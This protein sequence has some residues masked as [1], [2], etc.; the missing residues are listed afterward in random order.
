[1]VTRCVVVG[2]LNFDI[3]LQTERLPRRHEK[4]RASGVLLSAGGAAANT[5]YWLAMDGL[6]VTMVGAVGDDHFGSEC[7]KSLLRVGVDISSVDVVAEVR[8]G[9]ATVWTTPR[10]KRMITVPGPAIDDALERFDSSFLR[11]G[12]IV[13]VACRPS[14]ALRA[15][16]HEAVNRG[17]R[18]SVEFNG[19]EMDD[20][21]SIVSTGFMNADE[22][23]RTLGV[24]WRSLTPDIAEQ[25]LPASDSELV[26][27]L[28]RQGALA[29]GRGGVVRAKTRPV[30]VVDRTGG[31]DAFDAGYLAERARG[32]DECRALRHGLDLASRVL[33]GMGAR[34]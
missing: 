4:L 25:F 22:L 16:C 24:D 20:I 26:V 11:S 33:Q 27:T 7:I 12:D 1:M 9:L 18:L 29:V 17:A 32:G 10:D 8:T 2:S 19:R 14:P 6:E 31:G 34:P 3:V 21:R 30:D 5:A 28:G 15:F 13:H 23:A